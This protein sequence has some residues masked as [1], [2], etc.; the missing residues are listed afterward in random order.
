MIP[1]PDTYRA[2]FATRIT[3]DMGIRS[4]FLDTGDIRVAGIDLSDPEIRV[5][6]GILPAGIGSPGTE[7]SRFEIFGINVWFERDM[8]R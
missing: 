8:V 6:G 4:D 1:E 5:V 3:I 7:R 2:V